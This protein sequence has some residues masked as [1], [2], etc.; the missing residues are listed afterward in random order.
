MTDPQKQEGDNSNNNG[1][2][3]QVEMD[4][5]E[6]DK[7]IVN[8]PNEEMVN[9]WPV[10]CD[11]IDTDLLGAVDASSIFD[12]VLPSIAEFPTMRSSSQSS[13]SLSSSSSSSSAC[14]SS[15]SSSPWSIAK[16]E[17]NDSSVRQ[18]GDPAD[19][20]A[21]NSLAA[22]S[23]ATTAAGCSSPM[24]VV[25]KEERMDTVLDGF[26]EMGILDTVDISWD[27]SMFQ[28]DVNPNSSQEEENCFA[29]SPPTI[30][31][32]QHEGQEND[33]I[34]SQELAQ[35]FFDW[36]RSNKESISP[37]DLRS[38]RLKKS[39]IESAVKRLGGGKNGMLHLLKLILTW[40]QNHHLQKKQK[41]YLPSCDDISNMPCYYQQQQQQQGFG[42][43]NTNS[44]CL[45]T[46]ASP[47]RQAPVYDPCMAS[48]P[49]V[50][51]YPS[52]EMGY[53][54]LGD[55][56]QAF[57]LAASP[58]APCDNLVD[59]GSWAQPHQFYPDDAS[60]MSFPP[61]SSNSTNY[62]SM[63]QQTDC[64]SK[65]ATKEARKK[66]MARQRRFLFHHRH[67]NVAE[68]TVVMEN[69]SSNGNLKDR[70]N[71]MVWSSSSPA[72][73]SPECQQAF[74]RPAH[75]DRRQGLK[76]EK[77]LRFL[78][79]KVLKQSDVGNL[80]RIVLPKEAE[81]HLPELEARD[82][83]SIAM[84]DIGTSHVWNM[85]Y[86]FWPNNKSRMYLL[87]N[88]GDF[89]R[90]NGLQEGDF[91]VIYSDVKSGKYLIR[92]VKVPCQG[93]SKAQIKVQKT[94]TQK[95]FQSATV[96]VSSSSNT[97]SVPS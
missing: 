95:P 60:L 68:K 27:A 54:L 5:R 59:A 47:F 7:N 56:I 97:G 53:G 84:E 62:N 87:E 92:G 93:A 49:T 69:H 46:A 58:P 10:D 81:A 77:N 15:C 76:S 86:R 12:D 30:Y 41:Q 50:V 28:T 85:R 26:G 38:I 82:G 71:C 36:L 45:P 24:L 55:P 32:G 1:R 18:S 70:S 67:S 2:N 37:E 52:V 40:V 13:S 31:D 21:A 44:W 35:V 91:I 88:T 65:S 94:L 22:Q 34:S 61:G 6:D 23:A 48:F 66:R 51:G 11:P 74:L 78:L 80:G 16:K 63:V 75:V 43:P 72:N 73:P 39:T 57:P 29:G 25:P 33:S 89:V 9:E 17:E 4:H 83:I 14:S 8:P 19:S 64:M 90:S 20:L 42:L 3:T 96:E 79:Q